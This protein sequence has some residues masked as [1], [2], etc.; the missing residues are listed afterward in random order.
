MDSSSNNCSRRESGP[1]TLRVD[2]DATTSETGINLRS[3]LNDSVS[4]L[5]INV[6]VLETE[7]AARG[8]SNRLDTRIGKLVSR[9]YVN[10]KL[11]SLQAMH[12]KIV[13]K[14]MQLELVLS[15][16]RPSVQYYPGTLLLGPSNLEKHNVNITAVQW[17][18][19]IS[20][21]NPQL[22]I[23]RPDQPSPLPLPN[24]EA[25]EAIVKAVNGANKR[26]LERALQGVSPNFHMSIAGTELSPLQSRRYAATLASST[27]SSPSAP[28]LTA[29]VAARTHPSLL[30]SST[31][32]R[33]WP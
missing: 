22:A 13:S 29:T 8:K 32:T 25:D 11:P 31:T 30:P 19:V 28:G 21:G 4:Q 27:S 16:L 14:R 1:P 3:V 33:P 20:D 6:D 26:E 7:L 23:R 17:N 12:E 15:N 5:Q 10:W 9:G 24:P 2:N 18:T